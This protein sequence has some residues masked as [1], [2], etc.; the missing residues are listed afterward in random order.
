MTTVSAQRTKTIHFIILL[1]CIS[2]F[3]DMTYEGA[4]SINGPFL[5]TLGASGTIVSIVAGLGELVGYGLRFLAGLFSDRSKKYWPVMLIG[6]TI[7]LL[8]VPLLAWAGYWQLAALL[9][10]AERAGRA[11]RTPARDAMLSYASKEIGRGWAFGVHEFMDQLGA[12]IGPLLI[13]VV[14]LYRQDDFRRS[15]LFLLIPAL[16]ALAFLLFARKTHQRPEDFETESIHLADTEKITTPAFIVYTIAA[17]LLATGYADYPLIAFHFK[18]HAIMADTWIP[19]LYS[20]AMLSEAFSALIVGRLFDRIGVWAL[21]WATVLSIFFS[22]LVFLMDMKWAVAGMVLWGIGVGAQGSIMKAILAGMVAPNKRA[23]AFGL[24]DTLYGIAWF[25]GS[26]F[27][28]YLYDKSLVNLVTFS[29]NMQ[30]IA[31]VML[32]IFKIKFRKHET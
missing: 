4:R 21:V 25:G 17:M 8:S 16:C 18:Q 29:I 23:T 24:F 19:V 22:P 20:V 1:G 26:V 32:I 12:T 27:I 30:S 5:K 9:M 14:L 15:Y 13:S 3:G 7:N 6:Y 28:G 2:L 31:L 11:I 10:I